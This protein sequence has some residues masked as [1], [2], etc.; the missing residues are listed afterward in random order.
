VDAD[1]KINGYVE[2]F[3]ET[4]LKYDFS[5]NKSGMVVNIDIYLGAGSDYID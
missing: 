5:Q 2:N 4:T 1:S 3:A